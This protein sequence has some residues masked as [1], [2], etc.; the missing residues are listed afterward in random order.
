MRLNTKMRY[1]T[2]ALVELAAHHDDP[3]ALSLAEISARQDLSDKY[4]EAILGSL[5]TAGLVRGVR[6]AQGGYRLARPPE[7]ITLR[8]LF[9]VL[10]GSDDYAPCGE[11][12]DACPRRDRCATRDVWADMQDAAMRVLASFTL[13]DLAAR[14]RAL[15]S[16]LAKEPEPRGV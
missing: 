10:E 12:H 14:Q 1:G 13:A 9:D 11:E 4:L 6:G 2:R 5:R 16:E 8:D 15:D 7:T 3:S